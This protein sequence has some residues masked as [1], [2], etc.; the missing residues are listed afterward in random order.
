VPTVD[1]HMNQIGYNKEWL[2]FLKIY[3]S[4]L[5]QKFFLGY[6]REVSSKHNDRHLKLFV[7]GLSVRLYLKLFVGG[8]SVRLYLKLFV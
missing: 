4:P 7:G 6:Y 5:Q 2:Y 1:I 3:A 8:L